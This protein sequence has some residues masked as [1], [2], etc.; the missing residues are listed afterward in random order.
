MCLDQFLRHLATIQVNDYLP[1]IKMSLKTISSYEHHCI[2][3]H[4]YM[5][6]SK[7]TILKSRAKKILLLIG[8]NEE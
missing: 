1:E 6:G 8:V 2:R 5:W 4:F 7:S 3:D